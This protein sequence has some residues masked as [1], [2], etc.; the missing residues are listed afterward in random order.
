MS[1]VELPSDAAFTLFL[2]V[3]KPGKVSREAHVRLVPVER[4]MLAYSRAQNTVETKRLGVEK[5]TATRTAQS[6]S[7]V[8]Q[9]FTNKQIELALV[10]VAEQKN[11]Q[12]RNQTNGY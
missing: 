12:K 2:A 5:K 11:E 4:S 1:Y 3:L 10:K 8:R 6:V 7:V 9:M